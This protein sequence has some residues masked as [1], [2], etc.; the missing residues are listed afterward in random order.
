MDQ[1]TK[2]YLI[3]IRTH[4]TYTKR[5]MRVVVWIAL[6][7]GFGLNPAR[8]A[9]SVERISS[10]DF[11]NRQP[12]ISDD[13]RYIA[14][15]TGEQVILYDS[16]TRT[17]TAIAPGVQP[18]VSGNGRY[19]AF[20]SRDALLPIDTNTFEDVYFFSIGAVISESLELIS[21]SSYDEVGN[22][23]SIWPAVSADGR[24]VAFESWASNL[25]SSDTNG[26]ASDI[27]LRDRTLGQTRLVSLIDGNG[28]A[29]NT[30]SRG[31][32]I[33]A[34]GRYVA[35]KS[36]ADNLVLDDQ[37]DTADI[38][39]RD[40]VMSNTRRVS[41]A[42]DGGDPD[43]ASGTPV[44]SGDGR[45]VAFSSLAANLVISDTNSQLDVFLYDITAGQTI[46]VSANGAGNP[47]DAASG[48]NDEHYPERC[49]GISFAG[50]FVSF[51]SRATDLGEGTS[52]GAQNVFL[53]ESLSGQ[54]SLVSTDS[55]GNEVAWDSTASNLSKDGSYLVFESYA[56]LV[57][58][59]LKQDWDIFL[60][61]RFAVWL[62]AS[63]L[64]LPM[65]VSF[66]RR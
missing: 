5:I 22:N 14:Y 59:D 2:A 60:L 39:L 11:N 41:V 55:N 23:I 16:E 29:G 4:S 37:N 26:G 40:T 44:V 46:L 63:Q 62:D 64:F 25:S 18:V 57:G 52:L 34:D 54:T 7:A 21:V 24:F 56:N 47:G 10:N 45:Y 6:L 31:P 43:G 53:F 3:Q 8:A 12:S 9:L 42:M 32:S 38:F 33:S 66:S 48:C 28:S 61:D 35:F 1:G 17:E 65:T 15:T 27:F 36:W 13:G 51:P 30:Y 50:R 49:L 19:V 20:T 58:D